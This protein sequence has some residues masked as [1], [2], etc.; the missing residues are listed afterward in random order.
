MAWVV[1]SAPGAASPR[2]RTEGEPN[3]HPHHRTDAHRWDWLERGHVDHGGLCQACGSA[4]PCMAVSSMPYGFG[5]PAEA[6]KRPAVYGYVC[7][8]LR[9]RAR[10]LQWQM[11]L[12]QFCMWAGLRLVHCFYDEGRHQIVNTR[13]GFSLVRPYVASVAGPGIHPGRRPLSLAQP[14]PALRVLLSIL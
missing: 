12:R 14:A 6:V 3:V 5:N 1:F 4:W 8:A 7:S 11:E 13:G 2:S 10:I 9:G